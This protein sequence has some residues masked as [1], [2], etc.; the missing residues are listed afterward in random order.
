MPPMAERKPNMCDYLLCVDIIAMAGKPR[1]KQIAAMRSTVSGDNSQLLLEVVALP[2]PRYEVGGAS[3]LEQFAIPR[4]RDS[5]R[6]LVYAFG[7]G[8]AVAAPAVAVALPA[9]STE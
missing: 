5:Q 2:L 8:T 1:T 3:G 4:F 6:G 7:F 9:S